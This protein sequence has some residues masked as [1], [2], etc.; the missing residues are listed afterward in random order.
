MS[1]PLGILELTARTL[2]ASPPVNVTIP[3]AVIRELNEAGVYDGSYKEPAGINLTTVA[4]DTLS[5]A[6]VS[7]DNI[8]TL[9][10]G[11]AMYALQ[12][13]YGSNYVARAQVAIA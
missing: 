10:N 6:T 3:G 1:L 12:G 5:T 13:L 2:A 9:N 8:K 4:T 11:W 7:L